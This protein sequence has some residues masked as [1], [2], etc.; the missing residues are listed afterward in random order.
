MGYKFSKKKHGGTNTRLFNIWQGIR[1]RTIGVNRDKEYPSYFKKNISICTE[2]KDDFVN[3]RDWSLENGYADTLTIDRVNNDG[4]YEP[5]NCQWI[6]L[7]ENSRKDL[8]GKKRKRSSVE[9]HKKAITKWT[10][11]KLIIMVAEI[12]DGATVVSV[13]KKYGIPKKS[14]HEAR[15]RYGL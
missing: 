6:T 3:F 14:F 9:K 15:N 5:S 10:R 11:E 12:D 4:D 1:S 8:V 7:S 2:W 13:Q